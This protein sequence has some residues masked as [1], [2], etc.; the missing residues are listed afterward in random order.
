MSDLTQQLIRLANDIG[1]D[2]EFSRA[3]GG[4]ASVKRD[5]I[6]HIKP[7]GV[8]LAT[9]RQEELV[10]LR[11][12]VL[13]DA[14]HSDD[15]VDGDPVR[16]A[17]QKAQVGDAGGRRPSVEILFHALID[18]PLVL[19][20]HPLTA[21]AVTC[22]ERGEELAREILGDDAV[23]V[24]YTDPGVPLARAVED[25]R[26]AHA[27]RTGKPVPGVVLLGNHGIIVSG[28][29]YD[30]VA[31]R[32]HSL[33]DRIQ[34]AIDQAPQPEEIAHPQLSATQKKA[35]VES[36]HLVT[37]ASASASSDSGLARDYTG[38]LAGPVSEGPLIPD[39]IV[40]AGS[41]PLVLQGD[42]DEAAL[43]HKVE[44][45]QA[46]HERLP[47]IAVVP[48]ALVVAIGDSPSGADNA[49]ATYL[50]AVR[51]AADADR[52]GKVRVMNQAER[53]FIEHWEA[54]AYRRSVAK[55]Q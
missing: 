52:I 7:S 4:N 37:G 20:L 24:D 15:E 18:D 25:A 21:N 53:H 36:F 13:L 2:T 10:P 11:I 44:Q 45:F 16:V 35:I 29:S 26:N 47:I 31:Q 30:D 39:Q 55:E 38:P 23:W 46:T 51:V 42:E 50:D 22:N 49:L 1:G 27:A 9:L 34:R 41:L 40:Y 3:G 33:T 32:V 43:S 6:L 19:H 5:G 12:D 28:A 48:G 14:L 54:E 17:A 8:P